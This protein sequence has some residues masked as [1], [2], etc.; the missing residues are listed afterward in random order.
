MNAMMTFAFL[1]F[2]STAVEFIDDR[3]L[4]ETRMMMQRFV[5]INGSIFD[6]GAIEIEPF[7]FINSVS[8]KQLEMIHNLRCCHCHCCFVRQMDVFIVNTSAFNEKQI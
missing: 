6:G 1:F 2:I 5:H 8:L 7:S 4:T 3:Q